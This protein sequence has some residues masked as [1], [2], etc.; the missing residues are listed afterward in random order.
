MAVSHADI[1]DGSVADVLMGMQVGHQ[2]SVQNADAGDH[3]DQTELP[4]SVSHPRTSLHVQ[5]SDDGDADPVASKVDSSEDL[6]TSQHVAIDVAVKE[7][8]DQL[9]AGQAEEKR[10][11]IVDEDQISAEV[12]DDLFDQNQNV[13][14]LLL[15]LGFEDVS[16]DESLGQ[17][18]EHQG[19]HDG[20]PEQDLPMTRHFQQNTSTVRH[21]C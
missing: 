7:R 8:L 18:T 9:A 5:K 20:E 19:G 15:Y 21:V 16:V 6:D 2:S 14:G 1:V 17:P 4:A 11:R 10:G 12:V 3:V 13:D